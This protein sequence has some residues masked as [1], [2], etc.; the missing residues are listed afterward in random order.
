MAQAKAFVKIQRGNFQ[1]LILAHNIAKTEKALDKVQPPKWGKSFTDQRNFKRVYPAYKSGMSTAE[2]VRQYEKNNR[3][4]MPNGGNGDGATGLYI[5][6]NTA[7]AAEYDSSYPLCVED[8]NPDFDPAE[9]PVAKA[10]APRKSFAELAAR[11][12]ELGKAIESGDGQAIADNWL[13]H[14]K[15]YL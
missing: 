9:L 4:S 13:F 15:P 2:Y 7:P 1:A 14:V 8:L 11:V 3:L 6:L 10:K 12:A 5:N